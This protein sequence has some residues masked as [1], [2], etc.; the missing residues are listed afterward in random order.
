MLQVVR[1]DEEIQHAAVMEDKIPSVIL[2][3]LKK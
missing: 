1:T 3:N 2:V